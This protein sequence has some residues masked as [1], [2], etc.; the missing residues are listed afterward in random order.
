MSFTNQDYQ[1]AIK[2]ALNY[3]DRDL[4]LTYSYK[5]DKDIYK[6]T[7][8]D[9]GWITFRLDG[10]FVRSCLQWLGKGNINQWTPQN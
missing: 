2:F 7:V 8:M 3:G 9:G 1:K 4:P 10:F 6:V 5:D